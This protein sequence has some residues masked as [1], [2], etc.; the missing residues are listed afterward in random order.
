MNIASRL[1][2]ARVLAVV[3][4]D[5]LAS[6]APLV[7]ALTRG[8]IGA[9]EL[10]LRTPV[11][12]EALREFRRLAPA[13]LL[14]A[15]TVLTCEQADAVKAAGAD[16][17]LAPGFDAGVAR[18]CRDIGLPFVP[19]V[20]TATDIQAALALDYH[21]LKF[22]PAEPLGGLRGLRTLASPFVHLGVCF[23]PLGGIS[24]ETC[25]PYLADP[26]IAAVGGSWIA[27]K[28]L[29][30]K[31]AWSEIAVRAATA[32]QVAFLSP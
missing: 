11:S 25:R 31:H 29:L 12:H 20:A 6:V 26:L 15:G 5:E 3:T 9:V 16:F 18:H 19:G 32:V 10:A 30:Q 17:A 14:G 7:D 4:I 28:E 8:G 13:M 22:F 27:P 24:A 2:S 1:R 21:C 23:V